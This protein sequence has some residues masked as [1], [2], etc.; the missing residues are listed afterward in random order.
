MTEVTTKVEP[1][2]RQKLYE[3]A[4]DFKE[5]IKSL[6][7]QLTEKDKQIEE[8]K[9]KLQNQKADYET[10]Y[11]SCFNAQKKLEAQIE[12]MKE[13]SGCSIAR[14]LR[15]K[16]KELEA[17]IE[18][19]KCCFNCKHSRTEYEHCRTDKYEKWELTE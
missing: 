1:I 14:A 12:E 13:K 19:M 15:K 9:E 18:K 10:Y 8:L 7:L 3:K 5:E 2:S 6:K 16:N 11:Q 17:Q 4:L